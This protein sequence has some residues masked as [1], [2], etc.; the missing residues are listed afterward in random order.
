MRWKQRDTSQ[1]SPEQE[2]EQGQRGR[3][4]VKFV[5]RGEHC[6]SVISGNN[7]LVFKT[8]TSQLG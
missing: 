8:K 3:V 5:D 4:V 1:L 7:Y 2:R 6:W